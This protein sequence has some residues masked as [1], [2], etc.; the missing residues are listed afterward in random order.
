M[1]EQ[2][3]T[4]AAGLGAEQSFNLSNQARHIRARETHLRG[5]HAMILLRLFAQSL[6]RVEFRFRFRTGHCLMHCIRAKSNAAGPFYAAEIGIDGDGVEDTGVQQFQKHAAAL[7]G[8]NGENPAWPRACKKA[9]LN[10]AVEFSMAR[11]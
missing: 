3:R 1:R 2:F 6:C 9:R 11:E 7:F 5:R 8:F 10:H 4:G